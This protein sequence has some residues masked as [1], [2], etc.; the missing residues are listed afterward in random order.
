MLH[1][2]AKK[3]IN[4]LKKNKN[5]NLIVYS[6]C[7]SST[8][9]CI[10]QGM[11]HGLETLPSL[12]LSPAPGLLG[13]GTGGACWAGQPPPCPHNLAICVAGATCQA[14]W[15]TSVGSPD[16]PSAGPSLASRSGS[17]L[18]FP[19]RQV[20]FQLE[21]IF[22][23]GTVSTT[24]TLGEILEESLC[25]DSYW[26]AYKWSK[27][28][29]PS[30]TPAPGHLSCSLLYIQMASDNI[31]ETCRQ[32][33]EWRLGWGWAYPLFGI[34]Y[35]DFPLLCFLNEWTHDKKLRVRYGQIESAIK[36]H[37]LKDTK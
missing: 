8:L 5:S 10:A 4:K 14:S 18:S 20:R 6:K 25:S 32:K 24:A 17:S 22:S 34:D 29:Y 13:P 21:R 16:E 26:A 12:S 15:N 23:P 36:F 33:T 28:S 9:S 37:Q 30:G 11:G 31:W 3:I 19:S 27:H 7:S 2:M 35:L 1:G